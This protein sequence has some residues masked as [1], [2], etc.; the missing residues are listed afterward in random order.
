MKHLLLLLTVLLVSLSSSGKQVTKGNARMQAATF[1]Q[2]RGLSISGEMKLIAKSPRKAQSSGDA[3]F[4]VFN[5]ALGKGYVIVSGDDRTEPILGYST[6]GT[7]DESNMPSN[8][9]AWLD[10]YREQIEMLDNASEEQICSVRKVSIHNAV[11]PLI[12]TK[13]DQWTP[14]NNLCPMG[15]TGKCPTGC[16]ATAMAQVMNYHQ[17]PQDSTTVIPAYTTETDSMKMSELP[18]TKFNWTKMPVQKGDTTEENNNEVAKLMRYCG[19]AVEMNYTSNSGLS[20]SQ[21]VA[22]ALIRYFGYDKNARCLE[23][24]YYTISEWDSLLYNELKDARPVVYGGSSKGGGHSFVCDG[25]DGSGYY[26]INWGWGGSYDGYFKIAILN[27]AGSGTGGSTTTDGYTM[28]QDMVIGIQKPTHDPEIPIYLRSYNL[29]INGD[30]IITYLHNTFV[31][32][33]PFEIGWAQLEDDGTMTALTALSEPHKVAFLFEGLTNKLD[34]ST[35]NPGTYKLVPVSREQGT[36]RLYSSLPSNS[37]VLTTVDANKNVSFTIYPVTNMKATIAFTGNS[38]IHT[39]QPI[40]VTVQN[41]STEYNGNLYVF[42]SSTSDKGQ[43]CDLTGVA[44]EAGASEMYDLSFTPDTTGQYHVWIAA[45]E[46]GTNVIGSAVMDVIQAPTTAALLDTVYVN[47]DKENHQVIAAVKNM[48]TEPYMNPLTFDL[49]EAEPQDSFYHFSYR[50]ETYQLI[51]PGE[52]REFKF[53]L[54]NY[55]ED[56]YYLAVLSYY[57]SFAS[58]YP[59]VEICAKPFDSFHSSGISAVKEEYDDQTPYYTLQGVRLAKPIG[60]GI[61]IHR[62]KKVMVK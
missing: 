22:P 25:Y 60:K 15:K 26:H 2:E 24:G 54:D 16:I 29:E 36:T 12:K 30:S 27:P 19:Q 42:A 21:Y 20:Y 40:Q 7:F 8:M 53:N 34:A 11:A 61:Y 57:H 44:I 50:T 14:Y 58:T 43:Y 9:K 56:R 23:R 48:N 33:G 31:K 35:L 3:A 39:K 41:Q 37:Y 32:E 10:T 59:D 52:T 18:K 55:T 4:Y 28:G 5:A 49:Y 6:N 62:N 17:W 46:Q 51:A 13:W 47:I 1:L 38:V 45:D